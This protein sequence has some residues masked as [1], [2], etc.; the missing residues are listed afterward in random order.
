MTGESMK[1]EKTLTRS[2]EPTS[3]QT[4]V[5]AGDL[6]P[7]AHVQRVT[8]EAVDLR[9]IGSCTRRRYG[10]DQSISDA[11]NVGLSRA[12]SRELGS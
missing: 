6:D 2:G 3:G 9:L 7:L 11:T 4:H 10:N 1:K 5:T 8:D 12:R